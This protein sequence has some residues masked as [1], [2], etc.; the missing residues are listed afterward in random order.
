[1]ASTNSLVLLLLGMIMVTTVV[2]AGRFNMFGYPDTSILLDPQEDNWPDIFSNPSDIIV[3]GK[4]RSLARPPPIFDPE[5]D[6][7]E[8]DSLR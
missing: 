3:G 2:G 6:L 1:M 5:E 4:R 7:L 8:V